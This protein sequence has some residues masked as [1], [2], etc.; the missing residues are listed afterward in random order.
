MRHGGRQAVIVDEISRNITVSMTHPTHADT[1]GSAAIE[2]FLIP[3][4]I[5]RGSCLNIDMA[6]R[7]VS[8]T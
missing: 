7:N 4:G 1:Q 3:T 6:S 2:C 5:L 8:A